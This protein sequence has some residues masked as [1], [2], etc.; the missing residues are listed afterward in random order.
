VLYILKTI[1]HSGV[2]K[3][4]DNKAIYKQRK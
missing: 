4:E 2:D 1:N 3:I